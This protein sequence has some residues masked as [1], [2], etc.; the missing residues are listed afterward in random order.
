MPDPTSGLE[1]ATMTHSFANEA[2]RTARGFSGAAI[3]FLLIGVAVIL[4]LMFGN[5]G[6]GKSY[7]QAVS[8][9]K[10]EGE[11]LAQQL[12]YRQLGL[13]VAQYRLENDKLPASID[14]LGVAPGTFKD[15][16][17]DP[18]TIR[19]DT[20]RAADAREVIIVSK[21]EDGRAGTEDDLETRVPIPG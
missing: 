8:D 16:W 14:D 11:S 5:F 2:H 7:T 21:G 15:Q 1:W 17:G 13:L 20:T 9:T 19:F 12:D 6:G 18:V 3:L 10:K 4:I